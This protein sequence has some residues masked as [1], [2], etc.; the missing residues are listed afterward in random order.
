[1]RLEQVR[2]ELVDEALSTLAISDVE[3]GLAQREQNLEFANCLSQPPSSAMNLSSTKVRES[4]E[5]SATDGHTMGT[6][7]D[8]PNEPK[9]P[10]DVVDDGDWNPFCFSR[11]LTPP[12]QAL[13]SRSKSD[14]S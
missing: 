11:F 5:G 6:R 9:E 1:M 10:I 12:W 7:L 2:D 14:L 3:R 8:E 13:Q 4:P